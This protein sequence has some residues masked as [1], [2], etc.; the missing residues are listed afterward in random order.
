[1]NSLLANPEVR[2]N[3]ADFH[4]WP[5]GQRWHGTGWVP[6]LWLVLDGAIEVRDTAGD[7]TLH[8]TAGDVFLGDRRDYEL[9]TPGGARWL[10][11][12]WRATAFTT[13]DLLQLLR[14][15]RVWQPDEVSRRFLE[16]LMRALIECWHGTPN[17]APARP[18]ALFDNADIARRHDA[19][20][21]F[22]CCSLAGAILGQ[23]WHLLDAGEL[24]SVSANVPAWLTIALQRLHDDPAADIATVAREVGLSPAQF[25]RSFRQW[26]GT[27]PRDYLQ[28]QRL[29][30]AR[31]L[32]EAT[33]LPVAAIARQVGYGSSSHFIRLWQR[34]HGLS[35]M[36]HRAAVRSAKV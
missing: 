18:G 9:F 29:R 35:P 20:T 15:P 25:R 16:T 33:D 34:S 32:L 2:V 24:H 22:T 30:T 17:Y 31:R 28:A 14:P 11:I 8:L 27:S 12:G 6:R 5:A 13:I 10:S 26:T 7:L 21:E 23:C 3:W 36:Q 4:D 19:A 1:M